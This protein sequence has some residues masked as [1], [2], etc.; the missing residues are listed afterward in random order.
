MHFGLLYLCLDNVFI[1]LLVNSRIGLLEAPLGQPAHTNTHPENF[2][3]RTQV[4]HCFSRCS[5]EV[6]VVNS[7][8][9]QGAERKLNYLW[10]DTFQTCLCGKEEIVGRMEHSN[11]G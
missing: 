5:W 11:K 8:P 4:A 3:R 10:S 1:S 7:S 2:E 9:P 6:K